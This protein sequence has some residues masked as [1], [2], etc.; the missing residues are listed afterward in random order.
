M[1]GLSPLLLLLDIFCYSNPFKGVVTGRG[2]CE[3]KDLSGEPAAMLSRLKEYGV[4]FSE[5]AQIIVQHLQVH[6]DFRCRFLGVRLSFS[7]FY[8][9][10]KDHPSKA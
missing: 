7:E 10:K 2:R 9:S 6:P 3:N 8:K 4:S 1:L 5:R